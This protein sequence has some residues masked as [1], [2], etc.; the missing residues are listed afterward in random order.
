[1]QGCASAWNVQ[2]NTNSICILGKRRLHLTIYSEEWTDCGVL[3]NANGF[4][5]FLRVEHLPS[6]TYGS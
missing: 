2:W 4:M 6:W 5:A 3:K 1:M